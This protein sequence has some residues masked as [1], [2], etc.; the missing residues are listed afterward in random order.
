MAKEWRHHPN[1]DVEQ[2]LVLVYDKDHVLYVSPEE[3]ELHR[4]LSK[5]M[6]EA[7]RSGLIGTLVEEHYP[8][9]FEPPVNLTERRVI[10]LEGARD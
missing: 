4:T 7:S 9:V 6:P 5:L 8:E 2:N 10:L 3:I 1:L